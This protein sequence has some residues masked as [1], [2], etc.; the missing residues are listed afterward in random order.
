MDIDCIKIIRQSYTISL[1]KNPIESP[2]REIVEKGKEAI[3]K[4]FDSIIGE[5]SPL[6]ELK[7][8][9]VGDESAGKTSLMKRLL[10]KKFDKNE[11]Q[12]HG[13]NILEKEIKINTETC[14]K[15]NMWDFGGQ[16]IMHSTHQFFL[17]KRC[18]YI[19]VLDGRKDE[20][21][22]YW[23]K[24]IENF[25]LD[26]PVIVVINKYDQ[27]QGA[28][29]TRKFLQTKYKNIKG[30]AH[31]SCLSGYGLEDLKGK[32]NKELT[33]IKDAQAPWG[34]NWFRVKKE[35]EE[36][37]DDYI[38]YDKY[39]EICEKNLIEDSDEQEILLDSLHDLGVM[40][41]FK[42]LALQDTNVL[43]PRWLTMA[44][45]RIVTSPKI[46]ANNGRLKTSNL[47]EVLTAPKEEANISFMNFFRSG[48]K[49]IFKYPRSKYNYI[50]EVMKKFELCYMVKQDTLLIPSLLPIQEPDYSINNEIEKLC[51][52]FEYDFFPKSIIPRFI[53]NSHHEIKEEIL[54]RTGVML[55]SKNFDAVAVIK[56]DEEDKKIFVEVFGTQ[57]REYFTIIR[58]TIKTIN[59]SFEKLEVNEVIPLPGFP[60]HTVDYYELL[61][62]EQK[63]IEE[64]FNG[65]LRKKFFV[66]EL[67]DGIFTKEQRKIDIAQ[68]KGG[69]N[70]TN[71]IINVDGDGNTIGQDLDKSNFSLNKSPFEVQKL[72]KEQKQTS[73]KILKKQEENLNVAKEVKDTQKE[74]FKATNK[75]LETVKE[76][77]E[78][79]DIH[80]DLLKEELINVGLSAEK[81]NDIED[82]IL[83][84]NDNLDKGLTEH[85]NQTIDH[86]ELNT[87]EI[88][89]QLEEKYI[90]LFN[91][92]KK[93]S[94]TSAKIKF[95][96]PLLKLLDLSGIPVSDTIRTILDLINLRFE[97]E[98]KLK[99]KFKRVFN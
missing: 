95:A 22:E 37:T 74:H 15:T 5:K 8:I 86:I 71:N 26:S 67:L 18:L 76:L 50:I 20:K 96:L 56:A 73:K 53:V 52:I 98:H 97:G 25:G 27:H 34:G 1:Y 94:N 79:V 28:D 44:V 39:I 65:K 49:V 72:L 66:K 41:H 81:I 7:L 78:K 89:E 36:N 6:N 60:E 85:L 21:M 87:E 75:T 10:D 48:K 77:Q 82:L 11:K 90:S 31:I 88:K 68:E 23:L 54:W 29:I 12:T 84:L 58:N 93:S 70:I 40:L 55:E 3:K 91:Q 69:I 32:I 61:G 64:Y 43:N 83:I 63:G 99:T 45:Y 47:K 24:H 51:F 92:L 9:F 17:S 80:F 62:Y 16:E 38:S 19:L 33:E 30:F 14:I 46:K 4:W 2:P 35:L 57:K 13:I 42:E 59:N